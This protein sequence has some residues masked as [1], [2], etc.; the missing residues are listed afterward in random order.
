MSNKTQLS[1]NND[2]LASLIQELTNKA[3]G[4][5]SNGDSGSIETGTLT[6]ATTLLAEPDSVTYYYDL[7]N[8]PNFASKLLIV[9]TSLSTSDYPDVRFVL[10]RESL[11]DDFEIS[12]QYYDGTWCSGAS[13]DGNVFSIIDNSQIFAECNYYAAGGSSISGG[14]GVETCTVTVNGGSSAC[15][16]CYTVLEDGV[17]RAKIVGAY[18]SSDLLTNVVCGTAVVFLNIGTLISYTATS[19]NIV[20]ATGTSLIYETPAD[21]NDVVIT[22]ERD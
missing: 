1:T 22:V 7:E 16:A 13:L 9:L 8:I 6:G 3:T 18:S 21:A 4:G 5:G 15:S 10:T 12:E 20:E 17:T 19:G 14:A 2:K 11:A